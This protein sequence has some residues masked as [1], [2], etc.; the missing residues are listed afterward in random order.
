[1]TTFFWIILFSTLG[2]I[3]SMLG[4]LILLWKHNFVKKASVFFISFAAGVLLGVA[5]LDLLPQALEKLN[6]IR[7][8]SFFMLGAIST[9]FII[10]RFLWWYHHHRMETEEHPHEHIRKS[11]VHLLIAGD[12]I[13][14]FIDGILI[15]GAFLVDFSL[16]VGVSI[17][18]IAHEV[19]QEI[20]DF[21]VMISAGFKRSKIIF[22]NLFTAF[23]TIVGAVGAFFALNT[24]QQLVPYVLSVSAGVF[25]YIAMS[26]LI[27]TIHHRSEHK[28]DIFHFILFVLGI[29]LIMFM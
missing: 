21:S 13:H 1:M 25:I 26:D 18:V 14:N 16:G 7:I 28:F 4:G 12:A 11:Q 5:F 20:A 15:A 10:E 24:S 8:V 3:V 19:P 29:V 23:T 9:F 22:L 27:P 17:G 6:D 2:S